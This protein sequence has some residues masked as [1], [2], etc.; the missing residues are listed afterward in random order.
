MQ[1]CLEF[2]TRLQGTATKL[3]STLK[4]GRETKICAFDFH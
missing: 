3:D 1:S 2:E 4:K